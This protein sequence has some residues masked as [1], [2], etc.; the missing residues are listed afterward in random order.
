MQKVSS[1]ILVITLLAA[2]GFGIVLNR[3]VNAL[4]AELESV[5]SVLASTQ[6]ELAGTKETLALTQAEIADTKETLASTQSE[7]A[8]T[9]ESLASTQSELSSTKQTLYLTKA[10]LSSTKRTLDST[11]D[12]LE[13]AEAKLTV[14]EDTLGTLGMNIFANVQPPY[15]KVFLSKDINLINK[16][17]ATNPT[18]NEL[19]AFLFA[20]PTD[21]ETYS[22]NLFNCVDFAEMLH[23]NA[24]RAGIKA[25]FVAIHLEGSGPGHAL[26]AFVTSDKGL[27]YIDCVGPSLAD[28]FYSQ[29][30][31][32][33]YDKK[34][35]VKKGKELDFV[36][37]GQMPIGNQW[38]PDWYPMGIVDSIE[39]Y[40]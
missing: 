32:I 25:A 11:L 26:N 37:I 18:W 35:R 19:K 24:E 9:K 5:Q 28:L 16:P 22:V 2:V 10:E 23:N 7:L 15:E 20:D 30:Y 1:V 21:D 8:D 4:K 29:Y 17:N 36:G 12:E 14:Y 34:A 31:G 27:V 3:N 6:S 33:E 13:A 38:G 40:W 39:I